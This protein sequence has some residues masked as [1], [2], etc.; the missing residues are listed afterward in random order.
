MN[1]SPG[2][3]GLVLLCGLLGF[4]S[5]IAGTTTTA[6]PMLRIN[7]NDGSPQQVFCLEAMP[8]TIQVL[9]DETF[10]EVEAFPE[11]PPDDIVRIDS[12]LADSDPNDAWQE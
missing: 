3:F 9:N 8:G 4:V 5:A 12:F 7:F 11:C 6:P 2:R 10:L 1:F